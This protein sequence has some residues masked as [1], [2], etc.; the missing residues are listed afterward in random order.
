MTVLLHFSTNAID[1]IITIL[2]RQNL[3]FNEVKYIF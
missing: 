2:L 1:C 3:S